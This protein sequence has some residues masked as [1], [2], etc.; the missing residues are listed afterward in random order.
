[1]AARRR[2]AGRASRRAA[3]TAIRRPMPGASRRPDR[4]PGT[5]SGAVEAAEQLGQARV[6]EVRRSPR[7]AP[8]RPRAPR[9]RS[10]SAQSPAAQMALSCGQIVPEVV[11][12][13]VVAGHVGATA[14]GC[15][16]RSTARGRCSDVA[17]RARARSGDAMPDHRAWP[18]LEATPSTCR[19]S[20]VEGH[21]VGARVVHPERRL[22]P[23]RAS[24]SA[25]ASWRSA[26]SVLAAQPGQARHPAPG[27]V[28][29][30]P[31][32][33]PARSGPRPAGR[34]GSGSR[35]PSPSS[36]G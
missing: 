6:A 2:A 34:R 11:A 19:L 35:R 13:R 1:M 23:R 30:A 25:A 21:R 17:R 31:G 18:A 36:P 5:A 29:V 15:P 10:R 4:A 7:A 3:G 12:D 14:C 33:R 26:S 22:E 8:R 24:C 27:P 20:R 28:D 32:P 9:R 16:S